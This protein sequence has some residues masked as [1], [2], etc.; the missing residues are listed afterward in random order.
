MNIVLALS[1]DEFR[2]SIP[3]DPELVAS[4]KRL[5]GRTWHK[6]SKTWRVPASPAALDQMRRISKNHDLP[7]LVEPSTVAR[8]E[9]ER[10]ADERAARIAATDAI[11]DGLAVDYQFRTE[12]YQHQRAGLAFLQHARGG[13]LLW[14]MGLGKTKTA[15]D[16]CE[17]LNEQ[18]VGRDIR[19]LVITPNS[20]V[21]NW[22]EEIEKHAGSTDYA[23]LVAPMTLV[24]RARMCAR[25]MYTVTNTEVMSAGPMAKAV[26]D[27]EWD[28]VI[29]DE[30][31]R[32]KN[33]RALRTKNMLK[34][35]A[36]RRI[37]LTGTPLTN[38]PQDLWAPLTFVRPGLLGSWWTFQ[39]EYLL[40][41]HFGNVIGL[42][43]GGEEKLRDKMAS[44]GYRRTK[45]EVLDLPP[46]VYEDRHVEMTT[47]QAQKYRTMRD[48]LRL[49]I[50]DTG[51]T[52]VAH[53]ILTQLLRLAQVTAGLYGEGDEYTWDEDSAKLKELDDLLNT[54]LAGKSVVIFGLYR[55]ELEELSKRYEH[56]NWM[57]M[58]PNEGPGIIYG[59]VKPATRQRII[60]E[61]Q[62]GQRRLLF[63]QAH[64]GGIGINL[65]AAQTAIYYTRGWSLEDYLQSQDRLH[66]IGQQGTVNIIH[67]VATGTIDEQIAKAL[68]AK[69]DLSRRITGDAAR[70]L[71]SEV[72]R[73]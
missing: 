18:T 50:P 60:N 32:F 19:V 8:M 41:D 1:G 24:N 62:S 17:W 63:A 70:S 29:L 14:E 6:P 3:Y 5:P 27:Y 12:P 71:A 57:P 13:G 61:F 72:L 49:E 55:R 67:L 30:A 21:Q 26:L 37:I 51:D 36:D 22:G 39:Q 10:Q 54:D 15:I 48:E 20:V 34:V 45:A 25:K 9:Q 16:Y 64:S 68:K 28:V 38:S 47:A 46:K 40:R 11:P 35:K 65:T 4:I 59:G 44:I 31:H 23:L 42:R 7:L 33:P 66:R 58:G 43:A 56:A 53:S 69:S 52:I 73:R 2:I